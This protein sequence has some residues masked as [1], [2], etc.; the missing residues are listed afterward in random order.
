MLSRIDHARKW[1]LILSIAGAI[2]LFL[3]GIVSLVAYAYLAHRT[4]TIHGWRDPTKVID[5]KRVRPDLALLPLAGIPSDAAARQALEA[6]EPDTAFAIVIY[7]TDLDNATRGGLLELVGE[8]LVEVD[9]REDASLC[10]QIAHDLAALGPDMADIVRFDLSLSAARGRFAVGDEI[11]LSLSLEQAETLI[12]Y[13]ALLQPVQ[14]R[15]ALER[16]ARLVAEI[17]GPKEA[18]RLRMRVSEDVDLRPQQAPRRSMAASLAA[19]LPLNPDLER[20]RLER[21]RRALALINQWIALEG[22]DVGPERADLAEFLRRE[23]QARVAWYTELSQVG[24]LTAGQRITLLA[25]QV[26]WLLV[27]LQVA[28]GH[29]GIQLVSEWEGSEAEIEEALAIAQNSLF[30]LLRH[31]AA[32]LV[33]PLEADE[34]ELELVRLELTNWRLGRYPGLDPDDRD[35]ALEEVVLRIREQLPDMGADPGTGVWPEPRIT[36]GRRD[37]VLVGGPFP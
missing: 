29:F 19:P 36:D 9:R 16:L 27:K 13:S 22:G 3:T 35:A 17:D 1:L 18:N 20:L 6:G 21:Q 23:D 15:Q 12:R 28:R 11:G 31:Q 2:F 5:A 32:R 30:I 24:K 37:Y 8:R 25:E 26:S 34:V 4:A 7:A 33:N 10:F 14:R